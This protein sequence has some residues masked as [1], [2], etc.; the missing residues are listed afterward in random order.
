M[1]RVD[2]LD[3]ETAQL[4][5][6]PCLNCVEPHL[7]GHPVLGQLDIDNAAGQAGAVNRGVGFAQDVRDCADVVLV[8]MG[9]EIAAQLGE[10]A[11]EIGRVRDDQVYAEHVVVRERKAAVDNDHVIAVFDYGHV[12][13]DLIQAAERDDFQFFLHKNYH[14][15]LSSKLSTKI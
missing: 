12:F 15:P 9:D 13:A 5:R 14:F 1:V 6:L 11:L 3:R 4:D 10:V 8:G 2:K 7:L